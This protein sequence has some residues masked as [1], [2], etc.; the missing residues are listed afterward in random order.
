MVQYIKTNFRNIDWKTKWY[1][2]ITWTT[3]TLSNY[4]EKRGWADEPH[5]KKC[6][7]IVT[8]ALMEPQAVDGILVSFLLIM[9]KIRATK[10][11]KLQLCIQRVRN[12]KICF[13]SLSICILLSSWINH[14]VIYLCIN[15]KFER[16][17]P[18][19]RNQLVG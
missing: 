4:R 15:T 10:M 14:F 6:F 18:F 2:L 19:C 9:M 5:E 7:Q 16:W 11:V 12:I 17:K 1:S 3:C 8:W 13:S